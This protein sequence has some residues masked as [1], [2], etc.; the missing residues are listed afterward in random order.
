VV[1]Q[2][3]EDLRNLVD[4]SALLRLDA[5]LEGADDGLQLG[6]LDKRLHHGEALDAHLLALAL[7]E[8]QHRAVTA[9]VFGGL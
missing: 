4:Y 3:K 5:R 1:D 9:V 2:F 7:T 6:A 8:R